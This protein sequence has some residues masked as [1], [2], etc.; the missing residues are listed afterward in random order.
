MEDE[1]KYGQYKC[2]WK[3]G[4]GGF[5]YTFLA[6]K[7]GDVKKKVYILKTF[8]DNDDDNK[9]NKNKNNLINE[10]NMLEDL[11]KGEKN[12]IQFIP[13]L[14]DSNKDVMTNPYY[15]IDYFS[16]GTLLYYVQNY[17][18]SEK[19]AKIIFKKIVEGIKFC[20][21]KNIC[22]LDIK[23]ANII[24]DNKFEPIIIDF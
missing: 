18:F 15:T 7:E 16:N 23:P 9:Q 5:G 4:E 17:R 1:V 11:K 13:Y 2:F 21:N 6:V 22:H 19:Q 8:I 10:I 20:H 12:P 3:V 14:Y 24:F